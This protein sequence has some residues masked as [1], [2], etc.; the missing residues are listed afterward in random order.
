[1]ILYDTIVLSYLNNDLEHTFTDMINAGIW[2]IFAEIFVW[3]YFGS[4][5][6]W[7]S[8]AHKIDP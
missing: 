8:G 1:M 4:L 6:I 7:I 5:K 2:I 3:I